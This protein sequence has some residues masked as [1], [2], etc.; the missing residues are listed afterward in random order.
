[1]DTF[2]AWAREHLPRLVQTYRKLRLVIRSYIGL[3]PTVRIVA[4]AVFARLSSRGFPTANVALWLRG[5]GL[6]RGDVLDY[7]PD[8]RALIEEL[9]KAPDFEVFW[10]IGA[11]I[12][13]YS[14]LAKLRAAKQVVAVD[15]DAE[16]CEEIEKHIRSNGLTNVNVY[17]GAIGQRGSCRCHSRRGP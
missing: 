13:F 1:M 8:E 6:L 14:I 5:Q 12:G 2:K 4:D 11:Q 16:Y 7:E 15:L 17:R 10:D 9:F 3:P